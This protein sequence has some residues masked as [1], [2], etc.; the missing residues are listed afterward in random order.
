[1]KKYID[2]NPQD[3][4]IGVIGADDEGNP[5][6]FILAGA[7]ISSVMPIKYKNDYLEL[8]EKHNIYFIFDDNIPQIKFYTVPLIDIFAIDKLGG[9]YGAV[10]TTA[11]LDD[12]ETPICYINENKQIY[13]AANNLREFL[14]ESENASELLKEPMSGIKLFNSLVDAK[15]QLDFLEVEFKN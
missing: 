5:I 8:E 14:F 11:E 6:D 15:E 13:K 7:I 12:L 3:G 9:Y 10:G 1:M 4:C 2:I